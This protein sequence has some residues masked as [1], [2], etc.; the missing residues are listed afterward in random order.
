MSLS[1]IVHSEPGVGKTRLANTAPAPRLIL[2]A[3]SGSRFLPSPKIEWDPLTQ[4]MPVADGTWE[5]CVVYARTY[6]QV[7]MVDQWLCSGQHPFRSVSMD[8]ITEVQKRLVDQVAGVEQPT[9]Q[10]WGD[11]LRG[12]EDMARKWR[13]LL[14]HPTN[15]LEVVCVLAQTHFKDDK[16][17][18][19]VKG[20]LELSLP[21]FFDVVGYMHTEIDMTNPGGR[22]LRKLLIAPQGMFVAKDRTDYLTEAYGTVITNPDITQMLGLLPQEATN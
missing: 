14:V 4:P 22:P 17:R 21:G 10:Q 5:N 11:I 6:A 15:P 19:W 20:Q 9:Q 18:P 1:I 7:S 12:L 13:D 8:T 2:D 16:F 3:E